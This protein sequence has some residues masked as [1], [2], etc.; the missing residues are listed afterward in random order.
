MQAYKPISTSSLGDIF[1]FEM[2]LLLAA[3]L[4]AAAETFHV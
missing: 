4:Q 3:A 2:L 1:F